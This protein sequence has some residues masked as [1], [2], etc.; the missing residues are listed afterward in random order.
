MQQD[1]QAFIRSLQKKLSA[2]Y[3]QEEARAIARRLVEHHTQASLASLI[4]G[5]SLSE[6]V[7]KQ[8]DQDVHALMQHRPLQY[9]LGE[10][11]FLDR[12][13]YVDESVLIP[14][15]ETEELV[16]HALRLLG[17][18]FQGKVL[19]VGT[20]SGCIA[21]SLALALT[22]AEVYAIDLSAQA[23]DLALKNA[24]KL[25]ARVHVQ[26]MDILKALPDQRPFD[27]LISNPPYIPSEERQAMDKH[28][29]DY[30]PELAL[31]V[32]DP[33]IFYQRFADMAHALLK[34]QAWILVEGHFAHIASVAALFRQKGMA[35]VQVLE[36]FHAKPRFVMAQVVHSKL[37][38]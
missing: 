17:E 5:I 14:R 6:A 27:L 33:L 30:E 36:D 28:V 15:P 19:D 23:L 21:I 1:S 38:R 37:L 16:L 13:F 35:Q 18:N 10:A 20:G 32:D 9:V 7:L 24:A 25:G 34:D 12:P 11:V 2:I 3:P 22:K 8:I 29:K 31:F 4:A 26:T